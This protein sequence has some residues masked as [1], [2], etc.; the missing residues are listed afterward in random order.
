MIERLVPA[1]YVE[2]LERSASF[3]CELLGLKTGFASDWV[4]QLSDPEN[5]AIELMLQPRTHGLVPKAFQHSPQGCSIVFVVPDCD[6]LFERAQ[7]MGLEIIQ[8]PKNEDYGQ[9]RLLI[10]D[11]DGLL[12]DVSSNCDPSPEFIE[13]YFGSESA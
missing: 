12:V 9:R 10:V 13:K 6:L 3:Y 2:D 4:V 11:P 7:A 5:N 1:L 8:E